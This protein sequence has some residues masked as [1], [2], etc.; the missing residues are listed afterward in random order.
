M[1]LSQFND[2]ESLP[3]DFFRRRKNL[4]QGAASLPHDRTGKANSFLLHMIDGEIDVLDAYG[5]MME[6][7]ITE[8]CDPSG[9]DASPSAIVAISLIDK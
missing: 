7:A 3:I 8:T 2:R 5:N 1:P 4:P 6:R 9:D